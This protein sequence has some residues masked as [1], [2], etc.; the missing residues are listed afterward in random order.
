[1]YQ[2]LTDSECGLSAATLQDHHIDVI[3]FHLQVNGHMTDHRLTDQQLADFYAQLRQGIQPTTAQINIGEYLAFFE[4]YVAAGNPIL[5]MGL[6][7]GLSGTYASAV[8]A[9]DILLEKYPQAEIAVVDSLA[10]CAGEG[11]LLLEAVR[12]RKNGATLTETVDWLNEHKQQLRSW[13]TVDNLLF[14]SRGGRISRS[15]A[16]IGTLL[17]IKP[18][19]DVDPDGKLRLVQKIRTRKRAL[20]A[21]ADKVI[22]ALHVD[23]RQ[24][25]LIATSGDW[26]AAEYVRDAIL[27]ELPDTDITIGPIGPTIACH[28]GFGCVAVFAMEDHARQ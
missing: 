18:L 11:R 19:L 22:I 10:A 16:A 9:R 17:S 13:F 27:K 7:S 12:L 23:V 24:P 2:L 6:S 14:L 3:S 1:M 21:L 26:P 20:N 8:Q 15:S 4:P 5:F 25:I 28:T